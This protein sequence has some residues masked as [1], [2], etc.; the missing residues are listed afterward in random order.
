MYYLIEV[1]EIIFA[2]HKLTEDKTSNKQLYTIEIRL[3][4]QFL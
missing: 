2:F 4:Q 3:N 1:Y